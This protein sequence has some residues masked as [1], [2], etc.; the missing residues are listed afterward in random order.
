MK[1]GY[2]GGR[3]VFYDCQQRGAQWQ[4]VLPRALM[5]EQAHGGGTPVL[6]LAPTAAA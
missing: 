5:A 3:C 1:F 2:V 4:L 6:F